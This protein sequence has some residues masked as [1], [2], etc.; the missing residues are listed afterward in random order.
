MLSEAEIDALVSRSDDYDQ[1]RTVFVA[2]AK[3]LIENGHCT[4]AEFEQWGGFTRSVS[5][6]SR[7]FLYCGGFHLSNRIYLNVTTGELNR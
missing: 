2:A 6:S 7:Y 3:E 4:V 5:R 1:Y